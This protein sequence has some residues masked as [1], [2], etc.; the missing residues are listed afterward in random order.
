MNARLW[1]EQHQQ[2]RNVAAE[3]HDC[4]SLFGEPVWL[5]QPGWL[6]E[7]TEQRWVI[8]SDPERG[9]QEVASSRNRAAPGRQQDPGPLDPKSRQPPHHR[10]RTCRAIGHTSDRLTT[11]AQPSIPP[12]VVAR[13]GSRQS[14]ALQGGP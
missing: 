1:G 9:E 3:L 8:L 7:A 5:G 14:T 11:L 12:A 4:R 6:W 13:N 2:C 10:R